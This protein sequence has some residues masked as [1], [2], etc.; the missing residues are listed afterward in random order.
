M[1]NFDIIAQ[2]YEKLG[3]PGAYTG[4]EKLYH[5]LKLEGYK[6]SREEIRAALNKVRSYA[7]FKNK[8]KLRIPSHVTLRNVYISKPDDWFYGDSAY[9][10]RKGWT[11]PYKYFQ[12]WVDG[13]SKRIF[14]RPLVKLT[15]DNSVKVFQSIIE[16]EN[17]N[18]YP[19]YCF[20]DRGTEFLG[21]FAKFLQE[22]GVKQ[23]FTSMSQKNKS[24]YAERA[25]RTLK[26]MLGRVMESGERDFRKALQGVVETYNNS[27]HSTH[28]LT[29][30]QAERKQNRNV[31]YDEKTKKQ[32]VALVKH[33]R[34]F[35]RYNELFAV[36]DLVR[37]KLPKPV[38]GKETASYFTP[39]VFRIVKIV[40]TAP[41]KSYKLAPLY[42]DVVLPA[43]FT[44]DQLLKAE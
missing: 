32:N 26:K 14:A 20:V 42:S 30:I 39:E 36:G 29:P 31:I 41:L 27:A 18:V 23:V 38:F 28:K 24:F 25:L 2:Q 7:K 34:K 43:S 17:D 22:K 13:Y 5:A 12:I 6:I 4:V 10:T 16:T 40:T 35:A 15:A 8:Y 11:G 19:T 21:V 44:P 1:S 3:Q 37:Y 9:L 33:M